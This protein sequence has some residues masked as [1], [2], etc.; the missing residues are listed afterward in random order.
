MPGQPPSSRGVPL[1]FSERVTPMRSVAPYIGLAPLFWKGVAVTVCAMILFV[2]SIYLLMGAV[3]GLRMGYLVLAVSFFGWMLILSALWT[4]GVPGTLPDLGPRG[5]EPHWQVFAAAPGAIQTDFEETS[6]FPNRPWKAPDDVTE[7][8]VDSVK[9]A[10]QKY[11]AAQANE[12]LAAE[13]EGPPVP[14]GEE[15]AEGEEGLIPFT[16]FAVEDI[17]FTNTDGGGT[18]LAAGR[19]FYLRGG[20]EI[21][22]FLVYDKGNVDVYSKSFLVISLLGFLIHLPLLDRAEK[23]RKAILTGGTAP[24]W[25]GPA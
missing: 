10:I 13:G 20:P 7:R 5:T 1:P 14:E 8:S 9:T 6:R 4:F 22:V 21:T 18:H 23:K 12:A 15:A 17:E 16:D 2:G 11:L 25:Y 3:F 19:G 24:P